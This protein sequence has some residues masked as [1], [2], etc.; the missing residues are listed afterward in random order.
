MVSLGLF[1]GGEIFI[2]WSYSLLVL[3]Q[4]HQLWEYPEKRKLILTFFSLYSNMFLHYL[5]SGSRGPWNSCK[6]INSSGSCKRVQGWSPTSS[7]ELWSSFEGIRQH[8]SSFESFGELFLLCLNIFLIFVGFGAC[9]CVTQFYIWSH[10]C[11]LLWL[12][13]VLFSQ[14]RIFMFDIILFNCWQLFL[15]VLPRG[16]FIY[17]VCL[18]ILFL[19]LYLLLFSLV[20]LLIFPLRLQEAI[21]SIPRGITRLMDMLMDREVY[22][23]YPPNGF[24][25]NVHKK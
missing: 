2:W 16:I 14:K 3:V 19:F 15:Q 10:F 6:C 1:L 25:V 5:S 12:S 8:L 21:L 22:F 4:L 20:E 11:S 17:S 24:L 13:F 9:I 23:G 18:F 7:D